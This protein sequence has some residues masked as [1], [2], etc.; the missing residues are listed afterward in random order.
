MTTVTIYTDGACKGNPGPG[1]YAAILSAGP[2][3]REITGG[4]PRTTNNRME[5]RAIIAGL[6]AITKPCSIV[7]VS[8]SSYAIGA[9][10]G[11]KIKK[12]ADLITTTLQRIDALNAQGCTIKFEHVEGHAGHPLNEQADRLASLA[13]L[14]QK[15][16]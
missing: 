1:G 8:D 12:N 9:L 11:N 4:E 5:L 10:T 13:A 14:A 6:E 16:A 15:G 3:Q 7:V 2:H